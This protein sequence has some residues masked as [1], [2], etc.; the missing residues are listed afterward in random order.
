MELWTRKTAEC[1]SQSLMGHSS[2]ILE[3][4]SLRAVYTV[5]AW[6]MRFQ[7]G[8][9]TI[10]NWTNDITVMFWQRILLYSA[11]SYDL[12]NWINF[13]SHELILLVEKI[14]RQHHIESMA[15]LLYIDPK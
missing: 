9:R 11:L 15:W 7:R 8:N 10:S 1:Y 14:S 2:R 12:P 3:V 4:S 13:R 6:L 5:K